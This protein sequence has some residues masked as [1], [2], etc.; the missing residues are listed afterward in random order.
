MSLWHA[1]L[2][3]QH[4]VST[5]STGSQLRLLVHHCC[6]YTDASVSFQPIPSFLLLSLSLSPSLL[7]SIILSFDVTTS[8]GHPAYSGRFACCPLLVRSC[9]VLLYA[10]VRLVVLIELDL[11]ET[12]VI[13]QFAVWSSTNPRLT[14]NRFSLEVIFCWWSL[15]TCRYLL[16]WP[17]TPYNTV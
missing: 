10:A 1:N 14:F 17:D 11:E 3:R 7:S 2:Q 16:P 8:V 5:G 9:R 13:D 12:S 15:C 4:V 6:Q